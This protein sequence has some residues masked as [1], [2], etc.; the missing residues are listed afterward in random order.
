MSKELSLEEVLKLLDR[1]L[2]E[3]LDE[4]QA[5]E[6]QAEGPATGEEE[7]EELTFYV[8]DVESGRVGIIRG[9]C[10]DMEAVKKFGAKI[11]Y[12]DVL[13]TAGLLVAELTL[14]QLDPLMHRTV[15]MALAGYIC[16]TK[17]YTM[18]RELVAPP[19]HFL[20]LHQFDHEAG[21]AMLRP[22]PLMW[23]Q[24]APAVDL[25]RII[26][27]VLTQDYANHPRRFKG[28][29]TFTLAGEAVRH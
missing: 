1:M 19:T 14:G 6:R 11:D 18:T 15:L 28:P 12:Q 2:D 13:N 21:T 8:V 27:E 5:L 10:V 17:A 26:R 3:V 20:V 23:T 9:D 16:G 4:D 25:V 24:M 7:G 29:P 22:V